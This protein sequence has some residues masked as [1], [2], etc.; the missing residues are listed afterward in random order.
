MVCRN[1]ALKN[2]NVYIL[3]LLWYL[4]PYLDILFE[5]RKIQYFYILFLHDTVG[6]NQKWHITY[7]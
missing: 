7:L 2:N 6:N 5:D 4:H 3:L 1:I